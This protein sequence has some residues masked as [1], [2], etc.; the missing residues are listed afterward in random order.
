[1]G[2]LLI[3]KKKL[4]AQ[5]KDA[6]ADKEKKY[7]LDQKI[8]QKQ[9][10]AKNILADLK[11]LKEKR[12]GQCVYSYIQFQ[13]MNGKQKFMKA[14]SVGRCRRF[15]TCGDRS[16]RIRH[17]G[18]RWPVVSDAPDP[19]LIIWKNL[20]KGKIER[21]CRNLTI[22]LMAFL[23]LALGFWCIVKIYEVNDDFKN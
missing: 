15:F 14:M 7:K 4:D 3:E 12:Q 23:L 20:G 8:Q 21:C 18:N 5:K 10:D 1:M 17:L 19:T 2:K 6:K 16:L 9:V 22:L 13:S 11:Q